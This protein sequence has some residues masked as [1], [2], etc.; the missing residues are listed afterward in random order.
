MRKLRLFLVGVG[1]LFLLNGCGGAAGG[2]NGGAANHLRVTGPASATRGTAFN[3]TV[4]A[5]DATNNVVTNYSGTVHFTS[6]DG[7]AVLPGDSKLMNGV[8]NFSVT[9]KTFGG[10]TVTAS[11]TITA[12]ISGTSNS[13][14]VIGAA[15]HFVINA[16]NLVTAG[17]AFSFTVTAVDAPGDVVTNYSGTVHFTSTDGQAVVPANSTLTNGVGTFSATFKTPGAQS[18]TATDT[19]NASITGNSGS[20]SITG[21]ATHFSV[22]AP[23]AGT[24]GTA[25]NFT[26]TA[27]DAS[28]NTVV[29]YSGTVHFTSS[30]AQAALPSNSM[31]TNGTGSFSA[32]LKTLGSQTIKAT[33]TVSP[34]IIGTSNTI[35]VGSAAATHL[36]LKASPTARAGT[37]F[38]FTVTALD[39]ANN[40]ASTYSG[41]AHFTSTDTKAVL[42]ANSTLTNGAGTFSATLNTVGGQTITATDTVTASINGASI[43]ITVFTGACQ[44]QGQECSGPLPPCC[45]GLTCTIEGNRAF[46]EPGAAS[47]DF[48]FPSRFTAAC[49]METAREF[50]TAT[51]LGI[52][53]VLVAGGDN[54]SFS[55]ATAEL[56]NPETRT[57]APAGE[58]VAARARHT[59]TLLPNGSVLITGGRDP[60]GN[61]LASAELFSPATM[62]FAPVSSMTTAR[63]SHTATLLR[64]GKILLA[65]GN[66]GNV[67]LAT[68]ELFDPAAGNF[69]PTNPMSVPRSFQTATLLK[70]GKVLVAGGQDAHG[71]VLATTEVFDPA[72][73]RFAPAGRLKSPRAFHTA[74][75]LTDGRV[76]VIGGT[77]G[78][79]ALATAELFDPATGEFS[80]AGSMQQARELHTST[81]RNDGTVLVAGG[82]GFAPKGDGATVAPLLPESSGTAE[83]FD[84]SS[85]SFT[86]VGEMSN[87]R[88]RHTATPLPGGEVI[89]I[90]GT[91]SGNSARAHFLS[92]AELFE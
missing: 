22:T 69:V 61:A 28:N 64:D 70:S 3:F 88:T 32:T 91:T 9:L 76:L 90:G 86:P 66:D 29:G 51:L 48:K 11:D 15:A 55:L 68:A 18:I 82:D 36:S 75:L 25:F 71:N 38:N 62:S 27:L 65:G 41:T 47:H 57:F 39:A 80:S 53:I 19:V 46:C 33:D 59:D 17:T 30:D 23:A 6:T 1:A 45:P 87:P 14:S 40:T 21:P 79:A 12:S 54:G 2:N 89:V 72:T 58:M 10:Q 92:S 34:S 5:L 20:I 13:I 16:P 7:Q 26:V 60:H 44:I 49:T 85:G 81:L 35:S 42:P 52:G 67:S 43:T 74:T 8:G 24:T 63:E 37:A 4:T 50:H 83:L 77:A 84:L 31:L 78:E 56:F 73:G